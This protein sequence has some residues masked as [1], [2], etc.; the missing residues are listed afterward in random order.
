MSLSKLALTANLSQLRDLAGA[1][2]GP[3]LLA[4]TGQ[5][6][7]F[8]W[9]EFVLGVPGMRLGGGTDEIQRDVIAHRVLG[10]P[11][12]QSAGGGRPSAARNAS[13][14]QESAHGSS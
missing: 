7:T 6:G 8:S 4:D 1:A 2:L 12:E 9:S 13:N 5:P 3:S 10:L 11:R 14:R